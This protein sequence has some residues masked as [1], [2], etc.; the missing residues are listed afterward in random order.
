MTVRNQ[1]KGSNLVQIPDSV[2]ED[3]AARAKAEK[4]VQKD[5]E[6]RQR[7]RCAIGYLHTQFHDHS[8]MIMIQKLHEDKSAKKVIKLS[9][10]EMATV[11]GFKA[12]I[13]TH[14][15]RHHSNQAVIPWINPD[16]GFLGTP[17]QVENLLKGST[18]FPEDHQLQAF[19][20]FGSSWISNLNYFSTVIDEIEQK[21]TDELTER[22]ENWREEGMVDKGVL[23]G[24][25]GDSM[26]DIQGAT[27]LV[28]GADRWKNT[29]KL[30]LQTAH[31][32]GL[33]MA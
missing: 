22:L 5:E 13:R 21:G 26:A 29:M 3:A 11:A 25:D 9:F 24:L 30:V 33:V 8:T 2:L 6:K 10:Q 31:Q 28:Q 7:D 19:Y 15:Q 32:K 23:S 18:T 1:E 12:D 16:P 14:F 20:G 4:K 27:I 17:T